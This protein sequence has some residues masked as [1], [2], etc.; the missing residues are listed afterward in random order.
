M[1]TVSNTYLWLIV[2]KEIAF[3]LLFRKHSLK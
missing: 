2:L 1:Q 3:T